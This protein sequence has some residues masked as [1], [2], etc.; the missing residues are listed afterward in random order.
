[1]LTYI[2][3][4]ILFL[5]VAG[6]LAAL[7]ATAV[8]L[9]GKRLSPRLK[10]YI[11]L[12]PM[13][14]FLVA[15][16]KIGGKA[17][18]LQEKST[19]IDTVMPQ[20]EQSKQAAPAAADNETQASEPATIDASGYI[21]LK[22]KKNYSGII[23]GAYLIAAALLLVKIPVS[24]LIFAAKMRRLSVP[25]QELSEKY[26]VRIREFDGRGTPFVSGV[27]PPVVYLPGDRDGNE[28]LMLRH[29]LIHIKRKDLLYKL[30][31]DIVGAVHFFNPTVYVMKNLMNRWCEL[32]CDERAV[33]G[34]SDESRREY[35][36]MILSFA[37]NNRTPRFAAALTE[38][39]E[40]IRERIVSVTRP[41]RRS[42]LTAAVSVILAVAMTLGTAAI[43]AEVGGKNTAPAPRLSHIGTFSGNNA[44]DSTL[45][46]II[47]YDRNASNSAY[48]SN[49]LGRTV[50]FT[51]YKALDRDIYA[52]YMAEDAKRDTASSKEEREA[53]GTRIG[54][55]FDEMAKSE[56]YIH[57]VEIELVKVDRSYGGICYEGD[58]LLRVDGTEKTVKGKLT[59][60]PPCSEYL[61]AE[62]S[63]QLDVDGQILT[64]YMEFECRDGLALNESAN[65][66]SY[67]LKKN[68]LAAGGGTTTR[69]DFI[70]DKGGETRYTDNMSFNPSLGLAWACFPVDDTTQLWMQ[71]PDKIDE[72]KITGEMVLYRYG[73]DV[74]FPGIQDIFEGTISNINGNPGEMLTVSGGGITAS[75][76]ITEFK[77][78]ETQGRGTREVSEFD[79]GDEPVFVGTP[80]EQDEFDKTHRG[81]NVLY[82][83]IVVDDYG[84]V[85]YIAPIQWQTAPTYYI[86]DWEQY[87]GANS[88][89]S[90]GNVGI[91]D[92]NGNIKKV[93]W[94]LWDSIRSE[95]VA[96]IP[97]EYQ[98]MAEKE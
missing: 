40:G 51:A 39:A 6:G 59:N 13:L 18:S 67:Y 88:W 2:F 69:V 43:A 29:E 19:E 77:K 35:A 96:T 85:M 34:L 9:F 27:F 93:K 11:W 63:L 44:N 31:A 86:A 62:S 15:A 84:K 14:A 10:Y 89:S 91:C 79:F 12:L 4:K 36:K 42:A 97:P 23:A 54:E 53:I 21:P 82:N 33:E 48:F 52:E 75:F 28:E 1:M 8:C 47:E 32:S 24:R 73:D 38:G 80:F 87:S 66:R 16:P 30:T 50:F 76:E 56:N 22:P 71:M 78:P 72:N 17:V 61:T 20:E 70:V 5:S 46:Y 74:R 83:R 60:M 26:G 3:Y 65:E 64:L 55:I 49:V 94:M 58:F 92:E 37:S 7:A 57:N 45:R 98:F 41:R 90:L 68:W 81:G 95:I 25:S